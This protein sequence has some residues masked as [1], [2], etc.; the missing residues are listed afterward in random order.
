MTHVPTFAHASK[1]QLRRLTITERARRAQIVTA[2]IGTIAELDYAG[3]SFKQIAARAGLSST[4]LISYHFA[5]KQ[6]LVDEGSVG[7]PLVSS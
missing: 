7:G 2:A 6:E 4:G 5:G 3:A 1:I